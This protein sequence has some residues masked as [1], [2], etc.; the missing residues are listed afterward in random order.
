MVLEL[1]GSMKIK[2]ARLP[3]ALLVLAEDVAVVERDG[4]GEGVVAGELEPPDAALG[5]AIGT[6]N[7]RADRVH[8]G[9]GGDVDHRRCWRRCRA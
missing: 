4:A 2:L 8:L 9:T 5:E 6:G 7:V 3:K 1:P